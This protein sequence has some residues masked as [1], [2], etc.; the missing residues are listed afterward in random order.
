V[1]QITINGERNELGT[2]SRGVLN[3]MC[4]LKVLDPSQRRTELL[5]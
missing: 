1:A 3:A 2:L 5:A 4:I